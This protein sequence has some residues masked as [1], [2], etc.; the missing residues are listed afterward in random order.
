M[1]GPGRGGR[2]G[3]AATQHVVQGLIRDNLRDQDVRVTASFYLRELISL[4]LP[5]IS[6][7]QPREALLKY[8]TADASENQWTAAW[9][10]TQPKPI[11]DTRPEEDN[12]DS[13]E[14]KKV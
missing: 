2:I 11:F 12:D 8:A 6:L 4:K 13:K 14:D 3:A 7:S 10:A 1:V 5:A 9:T